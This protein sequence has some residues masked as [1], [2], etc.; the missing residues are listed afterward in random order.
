MT[1]QIQLRFNSMKEGFRV[2]NTVRSDTFSLALAGLSCGRRGAVCQMEFGA[3]DTTLALPALYRQHGV[4]CVVD[5]LGD[6][7]S[8]SGAAHLSAR[9]IGAYEAVENPGQQCFGN[10]DAAVADGEHRP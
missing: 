6:G 4:M 8:Q 7:Q 3:E 5:P 10:T 9:R 2:G 1:P